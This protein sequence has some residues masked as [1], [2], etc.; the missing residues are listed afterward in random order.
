[1]VCECM[2]LRTCHK[3]SLDASSWSACAYANVT[4][5]SWSWFLSQHLIASVIR[6]SSAPRRYG[7]AS[8]AQLNRMTNYFL[9]DI[10]SHPFL[11]RRLPMTIRTHMYSSYTA[12]FLAYPM[13][14]NGSRQLNMYFECCTADRSCSN[15]GSLFSFDE[16]TSRS[17]ARRARGS[18]STIEVN[19][20]RILSIALSMSEGRTRMQSWI[21]AMGWLQS[22]NASFKSAA[23]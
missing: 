7:D 3:Q 11:S 8:R 22:L 20:S 10:R 13:C 21:T 6:S 12:H 15:W 2:P 16:S 17:S 19:A 14:R 1:M 9:M 4:C 23:S 18:P 5:R